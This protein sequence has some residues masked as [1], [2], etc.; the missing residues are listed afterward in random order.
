MAKAAVTKSVPLRAT[1][2]KRTL[3]FGL[4]NVGISMGPALD[5]SARIKANLRDAETLGPV[6][7]QYVN[8]ETGEPTATV[9][10][11]QHGNQWV[12]LEEG[13]VPK[14]EGDGGIS[15]TAN[16]PSAHVPSE[17]IQST[18]LTWPT[19]TTQD[20]GYRLVADYLRDSK[21][22]FIGKMIDKG[23]T[24]VLALRWSSV[25]SCIVAQTL[26]YEAQVR[27]ANVEMVRD[28]IANIE[29]NPAMSAMA[30]QMF[31]AMPD[32][33]EWAEVEDEYGKAL[34]AAVSE[35]AEAG[36]VTHVS[37]PVTAGGPQ[38]LFA[39]LSATMAQLTED[40]KVN[41]L[42]GPGKMVVPARENA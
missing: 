15:L 40:Q 18:N 38:D 42:D 2:G 29:V 19:D 14:M 31:D 39:A 34:E 11:Y 36:V 12:T 22:A 26:A 10:A 35:K 27:W 20:Q 3:T 28:G 1:G 24:K 7:Q 25:Y 21:R 30:A 13:E 5:V 32:T 37:A 6:R 16:I 41:K 4:V 33:F 9:R 23:T 17:W 8:A